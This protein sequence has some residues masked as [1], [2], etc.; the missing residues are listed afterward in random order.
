MEKGSQV[1]CV[2]AGGNWEIQTGKIYVID[3]LIKFP[4][5]TYQQL[6]GKDTDYR[7]RR[8]ISLPD[9]IDRRSGK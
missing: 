2:D 4:D 8:F 7:K 6:D 5:E 1:L 9:E 3:R